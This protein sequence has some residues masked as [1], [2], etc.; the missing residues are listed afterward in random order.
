MFGPMLAPVTQKHTDHSTPEGFSFS[1]YCDRCGKEWRSARYEFNPGDLVPPLEPMVYQML[2]SD[3][4]NAAYE[5]ASREGSLEFNRCPECGRRV[6]KDCF[7]LAEAGVSDICK[8]C[9]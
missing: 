1:F 2:W 5:R 9:L 7:Y 3:Q 8:D 4:H 6:C